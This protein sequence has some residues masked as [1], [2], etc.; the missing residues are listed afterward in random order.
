MLSVNPNPQTNCHRSCNNAYPS[1]ENYGRSVPSGQEITTPPSA[2]LAA[3]ASHGWS[4]HAATHQT[5]HADGR[6]CRLASPLWR[7]HHYSR[8]LLCRRPK[9]IGLGQNCRRHSLTRR[10]FSD[11]VGSGAVGVIRRRGRPKSCRV[12]LCR[13]RRLTRRPKNAV[14]SGH[15]QFFFE[16]IEILKK[17]KKYI[18][19]YFLFSF[20]FFFFFNF[21]LLSL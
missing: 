8:E 11:A 7:P 2:V 13:R 18:F 4:L 14:G 15:F 5:T 16:K 6:P 19:L 3:A 1:R 10:L 9:T 20:N 12:S 17:N 21:F